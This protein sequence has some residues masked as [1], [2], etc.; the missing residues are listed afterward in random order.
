VESQDFQ[1]HLAAALCDAPIDVRQQLAERG[2]RAPRAWST[3]SSASESRFCSERA[4]DCVADRVN[5]GCGVAVPFGMPPMNGLDQEA[6][7]RPRPLRRRRH[8]NGGNQ[9]ANGCKSCEWIKNHGSLRSQ[10]P[11]KNNDTPCIERPSPESTFAMTLPAEG[12]S[13]LGPGRT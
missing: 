13:H 8:S 12:G 9:R 4:A 6:R 1:I 2:H 3:R 11:A 10:T 7:D 5:T